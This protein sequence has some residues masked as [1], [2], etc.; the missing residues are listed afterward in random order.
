MVGL[1]LIYR[2]WRGA[3]AEGRG[4]ESPR[5][6]RY[7][8]L[9]RQRNVPKRKAT[10]L[11][12][13]PARSAGATWGGTLAGCAVELA[14]RLRRSAQT[15][16]ASQLTKHARTSAHATPQL[17]RPRHIQK[18]RGS[19]TARTSTRAIAALGPRCAG[20]SAL[21]CACGAER[22]DGPCSWVLFWPCR[23]AQGVGRACA[24]GHT[25][26]LTDSLRLSERSA[27][28]RSEFRS[29][30]RERASQVAPARSGGVTASRV[31]LWC[32][33]NFAARSE[34]TPTCVNF[35]SF[36]SAKRKKGTR[37]PGRHPGSRPQH[38]HTSTQAHKH[39]ST[40][41]R[42]H[43]STQARKQASTQA[44]TQMLPNK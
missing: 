44:S 10:L 38:K 4:R 8:S 6:A 17:L 27:S 29:A 7:F 14:A 22:S 33:H 11:A 36:L 25:P 32:S 30:P 41:A 24:E 39:T 35:G 18:G 3:F 26:S 43:A 23:E 37:P 28:A 42:K 21:R 20:A 9:L 2:G 1:S 5:R 16:T 34:R 31:A 12:A 13:T 19:P 40:Q 15:A